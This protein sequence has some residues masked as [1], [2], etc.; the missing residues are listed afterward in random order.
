MLDLSGKEVVIFGGGK[1]G[2][3]KA[4]LFCEYTGVTVV[5]REFSPLLDRLSA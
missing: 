3:R 4:S 1:V 2:E 5:S